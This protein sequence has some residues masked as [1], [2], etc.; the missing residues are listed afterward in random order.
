MSLAHPLDAAACDVS[1]VAGRLVYYASRAG[2]SSL[3]P[4]L[5]IHSVNAAASA[6]EVKPLFDLFAASRHVFALELPGFGRSDRSNRAYSVRI[7]TDAVLAMATKIRQ[8]HDGPIDAIALSLSCEFLARAAYENPDSFRSLGMIS[9]TGFEGKARDETEGTKG[10]AWLRRMLELP[11][12]GKAFWSLLT[13]RPIIRK[14][15]EKTWGSKDID[16]GLLEYD[17]QTTHQPGARHAPYYFV[18]GYLFS[19]DILNIYQEI[20]QPVWMVH[21]TRGDFVDYHLKKR[22]EHKPNWTIEVMPTG[23]FPHFEK[24]ELVAA[25]YTRFLLT[26]DLE[27]PTTSLPLTKRH[28]VEVLS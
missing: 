26:A 22:V 7:M 25:S 28:G 8:L 2:T 5:L 9:P 12:L 18:S 4:I 19:K 20:R 14:F 3:P 6:Y 23:A 24:L 27:R 1:S 15:L 13:T 11:L 16:A 17:A 10:K 21:G